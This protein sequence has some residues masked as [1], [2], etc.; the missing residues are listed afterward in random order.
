MNK[1]LKE[2]RE[3]AKREATAENYNGIGKQTVKQ[4]VGQGAGVSNI[5]ITDKNIKS[6]ENIARKYGIDFAVNKDASEKPP[7]Y[8][9]FFKARD[10]DA[11]TAAFKE[12]S[13]KQMNKAKEKPS[14][15]E[16]LTMMMEKVKN[17][18]LDVTKNKSRGQSL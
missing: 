11:V 15:I 5:E 14:I 1:Y 3:H 8:L 2:G 12:Y 16:N 9:V 13:A 18:V 4:L 7:K 10:T 6:F 17:Q